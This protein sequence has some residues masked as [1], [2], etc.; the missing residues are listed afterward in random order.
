MRLITLIFLTVFVTSCGERREQVPSFS[1]PPDESQSQLRDLAVSNAQSIVVSNTDISKPLSDEN[2]IRVSILRRLFT[3]HR[4][5]RSNLVVFVSIP[6]AERQLLSTQWE[7]IRFESPAAAE[8]G[9]IK[10]DLR[11][12]GTKERGFELRF[13]TVSITSNYAE[14]L[15]W[16]GPDV[17]FEVELQKDNEWVVK[18]V[19]KSFFN[20]RRRE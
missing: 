17:L 2:M 11:D 19:Q 1:N 9:E 14:I 5:P 8:P 3:E 13:E 4:T 15:T 20:R 18:K 10:G 6:D 12:K 16:L 7:G